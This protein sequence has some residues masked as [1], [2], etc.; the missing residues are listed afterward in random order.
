MSSLNRATKYGGYGAIAVVTV[1]LATVV[2][3]WAVLTESTTRTV[4]ESVFMVVFFGLV[5][6]AVTVVV[7]FMTIGRYLDRELEVRGLDGSET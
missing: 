6:T 2:I 7:L 3:C 1:Q 5:G 4:G